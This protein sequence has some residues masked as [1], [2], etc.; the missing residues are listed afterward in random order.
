[1]VPGRPN[2]PATE[3]IIQLEGDWTVVF[4]P[5]HGGPEQN[6][7]HQLTDWSR[8]E[9]DRIRFYSGMARY[10]KDFKVKRSMVNKNSNRKILLDLGRVEVMARVY[11]NGQALGTLWT[12]PWQVEVTGVLKPGNNKLEIEVV[13]LWRNRLIGDKD[14]PEQDRITKSNVIPAQGEKLFPSGL[15]GPVIIKHEDVK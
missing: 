4:D 11:L 3:D 8:N 2:F 1:M 14:L 15:M 6:V 12:A 5:D 10:S 13:N 9:D 7:F